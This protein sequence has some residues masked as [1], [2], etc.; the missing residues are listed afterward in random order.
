MKMKWAYIHFL[1]HFSSPSSL[2]Q[3]DW[4]FR[5]RAL[6]F[7]AFVSIAVVVKRHFITRRLNFY[8]ILLSNHFD[9][10]LHFLDKI[11][12]MPSDLELFHQAEATWPVGWQVCRRFYSFISI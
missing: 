11:T 3:H 7:S 4:I 10:I 8:F 5:I 9:D 6:F 1:L 2:V 12:T